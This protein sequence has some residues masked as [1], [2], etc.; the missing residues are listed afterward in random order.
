MRGYGRERGDGA[1]TAFL[2]EVDGETQER[3][4]RR[5]RGRGA[6]GLG[7]GRGRRAERA[8]P[9]PVSGRHAK[10]DAAGAGH[11]TLEINALCEASRTPQ[12]ARTPSLS[13]YA[14]PRRPLRRSPLRRNPI[15]RLHCVGYHTAP[16]PRNSSRQAD[17]L[18]VRFLVRANTPRQK[19]LGAGD[20]CVL[21][22]NARE[23]C[24]DSQTGP[25]EKA[26]GLG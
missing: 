1:S 6:V 15:Y 14:F 11:W 3:R 16:A 5:G 18:F 22:F 13:R 12:A 21:P 19:A 17:G 24:G 7:G 20:V 9:V 25:E 2:D 8:G 23:D 26:S 4:A 10:D